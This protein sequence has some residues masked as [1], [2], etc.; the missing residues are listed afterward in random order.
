MTEEQVTL[1]SLALRTKFFQRSRTE[2]SKQG[3]GH[4][5]ITLRR[6]GVVPGS[7]LGV[8]TLDVC[9]LALVESKE[10]LERIEKMRG[11]L[12][13][14]TLQSFDHF[15]DYH[16][17]DG[18]KLLHQPEGSDADESIAVGAG[19]ANTEPTMSREREEGVPAEGSVP[20]LLVLGILVFGVL[21]LVGYPMWRVASSPGELAATDP[22]LYQAQIERSKLVE[23]AVRT[24]AQLFA[25]IVL[26]ATLWITHRRARASERQ[27]AVMHASVQEQAAAASRSDR[28][29]LEAQVTE[30]FSRAI[31]LLSSAQEESR[32]GAIYALERIARDSSRDHAPIVEILL[33][34]LRT[35]AAIPA[36]QS[37]RSQASSQSRREVQALIRILGRRLKGLEHEK[38][39]REQSI[40]RIDL[41]SLDLRGL[42]LVGADFRGAEFNGAVLRDA[43]LRGVSIE[44]AS[45][46]RAD[47]READLA[48]AKVG[49]WVWW[50]HGSQITTTA[51]TFH[52]ADLRGANLFGLDGFQREHFS[53]A[54]VDATTGAPTHPPP[55]W[56]SELLQR[57]PKPSERDISRR[58][59]PSDSILELD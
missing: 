6:H 29:A 14:S 49:A 44:G 46:A 52:G 33:S 54:I 51:H 39:E 19:K 50:F 56:W 47:L 21:L 36:P 24:A 3:S 16:I 4:F 11:A 17:C 57:S 59:P 30:R 28:L 37:A 53:E 25:G 26:V 5:E 42:D 20:P 23:E 38:D 1:H 2:V 22:A 35:I 34:R 40:I 8:Q 45:L 58:Q 27:V 55:P 7:V 12:P 41:S 31:E 10:D 32:I 15:V 18:W 43:V 48:R 13:E 9:Y